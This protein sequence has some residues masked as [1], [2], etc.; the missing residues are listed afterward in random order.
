MLGASAK[1]KLPD[2]SH[3]KKVSPQTAVPGPFLCGVSRIIRIE[4]VIAARR[5][6]VMRI[7]RSPSLA[8][9]GF[10][11]KRIVLGLAVTLVHINARE[12]RVRLSAGVEGLLARRSDIY[13]EPLSS[14]RARNEVLIQT[15]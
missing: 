9:C 8:T 2:G 6:C 13:V 7:E 11:L 1:G 10:K 4:L 5:Q 3:S 12:V 14:V 15:A